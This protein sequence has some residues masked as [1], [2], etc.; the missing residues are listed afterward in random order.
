MATSA[1]GVGKKA[2]DE[3]MYF[4]LKEL[5]PCSSQYRHARRHSR[6]TVTISIAFEATGEFGRSLMVQ[7][8]VSKRL[9]TAVL[10]PVHSL[11]TVRHTSVRHCSAMVE[12]AKKLA[13]TRAIDE[14]VQV[15]T[16]FLMSLVVLMSLY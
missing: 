2:H 12:Q 6:H 8:G 15:L 14:Y 13:A 1:E 9:L 5:F 10:R 3:L 16:A 4:E 11:H 7:F